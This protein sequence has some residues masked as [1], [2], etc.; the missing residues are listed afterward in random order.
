MPHQNLLVFVFWL[1]ERYNYLL[2]CAAMDSP[3]KTMHSRAETRASDLS[4]ADSLLNGDILSRSLCEGAQGSATMED[5]SGRRSPWGSAESQNTDLMDSCSDATSVVAA[6]LD[7][8]R[9]GAMERCASCISKLGNMSVKGATFSPAWTMEQH[10]QSACLGQPADRASLSSGSSG[11]SS[12]TDW[13]DRPRA[14]QPAPSV[15]PKSPRH[16]VA[17]VAPRC[18][19]CPPERPPKPPSPRKAAPPPCHRAVP[20]HAQPLSQPLSQAEEHNYDVP[21]SFLHARVPVRVIKLL[22]C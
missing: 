11:G 1:I 16:A 19:C 14:V 2:F 20:G 7:M 4:C 3:R 9:R 22:F 12:A 13:Y 17:P 10:S 5:L 6:D 15:P 21:R 18:Q 8:E